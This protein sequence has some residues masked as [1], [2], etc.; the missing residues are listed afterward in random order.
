[1]LTMAEARRMALS[2]PEVTEEDHF[3]M[4]S[5]R[6]QKKIFSTVPDEKTIRVMLG[7][8]ETSLGVNSN[9]SAFA[10]LWWGK[11]L[12]GVSVHLAQASQQQVADLLGEAWRPK[13]PKA[14]IAAF[15]ASIAKRKK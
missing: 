13:A 15:N 10:E 5:Y 7:P 4:P 2:L 14:L 11:K 12:A 9:R 6:E 1:M 8:E 3:G